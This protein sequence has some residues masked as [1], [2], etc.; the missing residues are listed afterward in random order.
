MV[1]RVA[2]E[3]VAFLEACAAQLVPAVRLQPADLITELIGERNLAG[4]ADVSSRIRRIRRVYGVSGMPFGD[5]VA[6]DVHL[7]VDVRAAA[8]IPAWEDR[9]EL[10]AAGGVLDL[11]T[12]AKSLIIRPLHARRTVASLRST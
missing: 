6:T 10:N 8:L 7:Q 12:T 9:L 11:H 5:G 4:M 3:N 1:A 2:H